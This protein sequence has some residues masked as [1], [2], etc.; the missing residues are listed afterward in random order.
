MK[1]AIFDNNDTIG[2]YELNSN[3]SPPPEFPNN[4]LQVAPQ[5]L[6]VPDETPSSISESRVLLD[7]ALIRLE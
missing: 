1:S 5:D 7:N 2:L 6:Y 4:K 3:K